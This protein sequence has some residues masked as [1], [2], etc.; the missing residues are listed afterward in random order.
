MLFV[1]IALAPAGISLLFIGPKLWQL[2]CLLIGVGVLVVSFVTAHLY[3]RHKQRR[4]QELES[5]GDSSHA[6]RRG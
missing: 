5:S 1:I 6:E 3:K 2:I 4:A